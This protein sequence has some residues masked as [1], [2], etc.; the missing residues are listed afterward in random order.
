MDGKGK[1]MSEM[2]AKE[3]AWESPGNE[4][5]EWWSPTTTTPPTSNPATDNSKYETRSE[6]DVT[7]RD[8]VTNGKTSDDNASPDY[9]QSIILWGERVHGFSCLS[10]T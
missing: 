9:I 10:P 3:T 2:P 6:G 5:V 1:S 8:C 4:P 7:R